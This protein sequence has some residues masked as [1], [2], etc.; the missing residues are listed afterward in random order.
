MDDIFQGLSDFMLVGNRHWHYE[1]EKVAELMASW[2]DTLLPCLV[3]LVSMTRGLANPR[4]GG[5]RQKTHSQPQPC[6][7]V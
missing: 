2:Q 6:L 3:I 4:S 1:V 7:D 5:V